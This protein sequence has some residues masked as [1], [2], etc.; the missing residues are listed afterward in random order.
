MKFISIVVPIYNEAEN[1]LHFAAAV[2]EVMENSHYKWELLFIDDGSR[3]NSVQIIRDLQRWE[4]QVKLIML[5]R[6]YGH[7]IALTC[8][9]DSAQGDA[10]ITMDGDM[11]HPPALIPVL[12]EKWEEGCK[13]VQTIRKDTE[14]VSWLKKETSRLYY[15]FINAMSTVEVYSGGSDFR[16]LDREAVE[17]LR[18]Y[19]EHDR[20]LR[21]MVSSLGFKRAEVPFV[22]PPRFA[23]KSKY[24]LGKMLKLATDGVVGFSVIPLRWAFYMGLVFALLSFLLLCHALWEYAQHQVVPGWTTI[25]VAMSM[26]GGI[27]LVIMGIIG[28]YVGRI[29]TEVKN[30]P[31]YFVKH[32]MDC[33]NDEETHTKCG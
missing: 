19:R 25:M 2:K 1:V 16:L 30:R 32:N 18:Q 27:Q 23:G 21:G 28:E 17:A 4:P 22:A 9:L 11:Q 3:D 15:R 7:Q 5:A 12:L 33:D 13:V 20:F 31:L 26:F 14:G 24:N 8:G 10:V 29:F 6:N